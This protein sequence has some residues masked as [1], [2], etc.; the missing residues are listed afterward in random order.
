MHDLPT[1]NLIGCGRVGQALGR[2]FHSHGVFA[3]QG[4]LTRSPATATAAVASLGAGR[5]VSSMADLPAAAVTMIATPDD[6]INSTAVSLA[7][8]GVLRPGDV[9][10]HVSGALGSA[11]LHAV[12]AFGARVA[13]VHPVKSF[14]TVENAVASFPGTFCAIEGDSDACEMLAP[15]FQRLGAEIFTISREQKAIY[16]AATVLAS[17]SMTALL[18]VSLRCLERAGLVREQ[19]LKILAPLATG[20][21]HNVLTQGPV[22]ALTGPMARGDAQTVAKQRAALSAWDANVAALYVQL[23][24]VTL[25]LAVQQ[26]LGSVSVASVRQALGLPMEEVSLD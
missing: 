4:V 25:E 10:F 20:A 13:S 15:A 21:L 9:V 11:D 7:S 23:G 8:A 18:E 19:G 16:H 17:N 26:G 22:Q 1:M 6:Q 2:L 5:P 3:I 14:A 24:A 12:T